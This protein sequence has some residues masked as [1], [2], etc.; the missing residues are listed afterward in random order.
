MSQITFDYAQIGGVNL[1]YAKA[2]SG[3]KLVLLLHGFPEFCYSW[4]HQLEALSDEYTVVAP[5]LRGYNLSDKP[6]KV[7]D[8]LLEY[9]VDDVLGLI[10]HFGREQA[11]LI[12]HDWGAIIAWETARQHPEAIWKLGCLQVPPIFV[13][14]KNLTFRQALASFYMFFFL[15]PLI[16]E[17]LFR[18]NDY[19]IGG[20]LM[21]LAAADYDF[22]RPKIC[23]NTKI[24]G[25]SKM[26]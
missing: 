8:Y 19:N 2:G 25:D 13:W 21:R 20:K 16:P 24:R 12:G 4:R 9:L 15:I 5:D 3:D 6:D 18:L 10:N 1:H 26:P 22:F 11:A 7:A 23:F 14:Q 17:W